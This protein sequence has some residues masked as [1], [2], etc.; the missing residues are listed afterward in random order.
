MAGPVVIL[1]A[2]FKVLVGFRI[3]LS[4]AGAVCRLSLYS[5]CFPIVALFLLSLF[6]FCKLLK[7]EMSISTI[8]YS[9]YESYYMTHAV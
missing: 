4:P 8:S 7:K 2:L 6:T 5:F 3:G 9:P 1:S